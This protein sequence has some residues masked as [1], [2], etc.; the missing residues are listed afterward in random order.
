MRAALAI[1]AMLA[2]A[3]ADDPDEVEE[4]GITETIAEPLEL[5]LASPIRAGEA[6]WVEVRTIGGGC[7]HYGSTEVFVEEGAPTIIP[8]DIR[9]IPG[10]HE[11]CLA[12]LLDLRHR[13]TIM[14]EAPG[15][16]V[17]RVYGR[18]RNT[19][20]TYDDVRYDVAIEVD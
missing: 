5:L 19:D 10:P 6:F 1:L 9:F 14:F 7:I 8:W 18:R 15:T 20:N 16:N 2:P 12:N 3:C 4:V 17:L 13:A 11:G